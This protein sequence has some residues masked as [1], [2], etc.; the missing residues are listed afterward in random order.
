M[1]REG[2]Q[3]RG[4]R[5]QN[6][7]DADPA[8]LPEVLQFMRLLWALVH[9]LDRASKRMSHDLGVTG[10]QR[11]ALRVIGL[12]PDISA[13]QLAHMLHIHPSTLTGILQRLIEQGLVQ[14]TSMT[15]D[16][17]RAQLRLSTRGARIDRLNTGTVEAAVSA[18]LRQASARDRAATQRVIS[19]ISEQ[20]TRQLG[21]DK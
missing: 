20:I 7:G 3:M 9:G 14:R 17:R 6:R 1:V 4:S 10:P 15:S 11:L 16:R 18:A 21:P 13:G 2:R 12:F 19:A 8:A 5:E